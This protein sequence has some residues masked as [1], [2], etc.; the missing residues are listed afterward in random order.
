MP[1]EPVDEVDEAIKRKATIE[2]GGEPLVVVL[3]VQ[4]EVVV[5]GVVCHC[6]DSV[7]FELPKCVV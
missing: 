1:G 3:E 7:Q 5:V 2:L 4:E 6:L